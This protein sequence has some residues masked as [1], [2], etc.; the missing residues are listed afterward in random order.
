MDD[1]QM[2]KGTGA[3]LDDRVRATSDHQRFLRLPSVAAA[4]GGPRAESATQQGNLADVVA[5]VHQ[6]L[7]QNGD[8]GRRAP[9]VIG[10]RGFD[11]HRQYVRRR[12]RQRGDFCEQ[13]AEVDDR[14]APVF[15]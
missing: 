2:I 6:D 4:F 3:L 10:M 13:V 5:V 8:H 9:G 7:P 15:G 11:F 1:E 12:G 14:F